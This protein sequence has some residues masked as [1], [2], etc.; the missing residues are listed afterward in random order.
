MA[1]LDP[2]KNAVDTKNTKSGSTQP[3]ATVAVVC[4]AALQEEA[5]SYVRMLLQAGRDPHNIQAELDASVEAVLISA[6]VA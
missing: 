6:R 1:P 5:L 2:N 4:V 3:G